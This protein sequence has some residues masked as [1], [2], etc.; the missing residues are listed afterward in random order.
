M[1]ELYN[2]T[3][4][5]PT[6]NTT[7]TALR[8]ISIA[9]RK[10]EFVA[11]LGQSG[12]GKTTLLNIIG[13]L[14]KYTDGDLV[15][16]GIST[17]EYKDSNWDAY[18]N[19]SIG[20]VFQSYNLIPHQTV[21]AN[22]EL[23]LTLSGVS[24]TERKERAIE[25]L[26]KVGLS[27]QLYKKPNQMSGGQMQ[28]VAIARALVNNP[29][30]LL[31]DEPTGALDSETSIQIMDILKEIAKDK[32]V[33]MVTHNPELADTYANRI[34]NLLD[35]RIIGDSNPYD[36]KKEIEQPKDKVVKEIKKNKSMSLWTALALSFNNLLTKKG[37]TIL[38]AIAGSIGIIGIAL[39]LSIS[40]GV[41][42]YID[43]VQQETL[44]SFPIQIE[45]ESTN[46]SSLLSSLMGVNSEETSDGIAK[47]DRTA[48]YGN[49]VM[50]KMMKAM[51]NAEVSTNNLEKFKVYLDQHKEEL[52]NYTTAIQYGYDIKLNIY[53]TDPNGEYAKA[54]FNDLMKGVFSGGSMSGGISSIMESASGMNVWQELL[55]DP[56]SGEIS[57]LISDQYDLIYGKWPK[58]K[59]EILLVLN[60]NNEI[61]D[62]TLYSLGLVDKQTMINATMAAMMGKEDSGWD[63][64][65]GKSW[66]Y[67]DICNINLK[68]SLPTDY[69]QFDEAQNLWIN[70]S[71]NQALLNSVINKGI[72]LKISGIV[73]PSEDATSAFLNGSLC[74]T[75]ALT[76]YY[77]KSLLKSDIIIDQM[78]NDDY[79]VL[80]GLPFI[81]ED[82]ENLTAA[83]QIKAFKDYASG[84]TDN[85]KLKLYQKILAAP[86]ESEVQ[87]TIDSL[88]A[89]YE[90][91]TAEEI[92][93]DITSQYAQ[94]LGYSEE[95]IRD[96]LSGY[97]K[98]ELIAIIMETVKQ[99]IVQQYE[100]KAKAEIERIYGTPS[101]SELQMMKMMITS[102]MYK[103]IP[104]SLPA[105]QQAMM[106]KLINVEF[107]ASIWG[108]KTGMTTTAAKSVLNSMTDEEF[109]KI[110]NQALDSKAEEVYSQYSG[111]TS[112]SD[113]TAKV[114]KA[115]D[116]YL[117]TL[118]D[119]DFVY[120]YE[121]HMPDKM[122][123]KTKEEIL[124]FLGL[125]LEEDP[126]YIYIY[127]IDFENKEI[128]ANMIKDYNATVAEEDKIEYTD[129]VAILMSSVSD[130]ITAISVVLIC[131]VS[132]SLVVSS[133]M[134]GIITYISVLERTKEIGILRAVGASKKDISR[135]FNAETMIIGLLAGV[136]GIVVTVLL[137]FPVSW[138]AR[139]A[140]NIQN[141]TAVLPWYG[142]LLI[143]LS[144]GLTLIAGL[145]PSRMAAKKDPV[146]ALRTE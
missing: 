126:D 11:I 100:E 115:F 143:L 46:I 50:Y 10:S 145:L 132:I 99:M 51:L 92:I 62:V 23:A 47:E 37:R 105:E 138:I 29:D 96:M 128:I 4:E 131:F 89:Q 32:L 146:V 116:E 48:V 42:N 125:K 9:F 139:S 31:A 67:E 25:A 8:G 27:D 20:F 135:V 12:C 117:T 21:L 134:I 113:K 123:D 114:A 22:V 102:E 49:P 64:Y 129:M 34:V 74:Y 3:K 36:V 72:D 73:K 83:E 107:V 86:K 60:E 82:D 137:C 40:T 13:G 43:T 122:S 101:S 136:V 110:F 33:I 111:M 70:I 2:I 5:Y 69:Y 84:L 109:N 104:S 59:N 71:E 7:L 66:S 119:K 57:S 68:L 121:N 41:N 58:E 75:S 65:E 14:D 81:I 54:D 56:K 17:K 53:A 63:E 88:M 52:A 45:K 28:R 140:T 91:K 78:E 90:N 30:I 18:R 19:H 16:N 98:D 39:I 79:N 38:T 120:L 106:K 35:G 141:L 76:T 95:L 85:E 108:E 15:I 130:I 124:E 77:I 112:N 94:E 97:S 44:S 93:N 144:V 103:M 55:T 1:L 142:Y 133:I 87:K 80:T 26:T 127:P 61:S 24:K 6:G 118:T